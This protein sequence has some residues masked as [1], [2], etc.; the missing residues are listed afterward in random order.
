M[1]PMLAGAALATAML[2]A[3]VI[4]LAIQRG[5]T[6]TV[7]AVDELL[8]QRRPARLLALLEASLWVAGGLLLAHQWGALPALP[9]AYALNGWTLAG[10][11]LLGTGA[12][13]NRACV[14]GAIARLGSG[15]WAWAA[16]PVGFYIGCLSVNM[17]FAP[18]AP[19]RLAGGS[20]LFGAP[21][22]LAGLFIAW[23][24][25]RVLQWM[26]KG[27]RS[28]T[29][30]WSAHAAT[31]VIGLAFVALLLLAG[32]WTYTDVLADLARDMAGSLAARVLLAL[33]LLA[34]ALTGGALTGKL[35]RRAPAW[36]D[37]LR[38]L[39]G[40]LL[41]GWGSLLIPGGNDG[42]VLLG[43]PLLWPYAW[44]SFATMCAVVAVVAVR[45]R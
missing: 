3:A 31:I 26:R 39:A 41:M 15:E 36:R 21:A 30:P 42:L 40:G 9:P 22:W 1:N 37:V 6:C 35:R 38:C 5:A 29:Q 11:A 10:A 14:F 45:R 18:P 24:G 34:G 33:A 2:C 4:G 28:V 44:A 16:T 32:A 25:F 19:M 7:A 27:R 12:V 17:V 23:A 43:M 8:T 20:P 13:V